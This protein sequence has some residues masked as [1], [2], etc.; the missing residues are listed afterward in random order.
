M[1]PVSRHFITYVLTAVPLNAV[2]KLASEVSCLT[3]MR[4]N[5]HHEL[6]C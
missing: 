6:R 4:T 2:P 3:Y 5:S 1:L